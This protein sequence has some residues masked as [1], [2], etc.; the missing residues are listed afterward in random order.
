MYPKEKKVSIFAHVFF[1]FERPKRSTET[2][3]QTGKEASRLF[4]KT[5]EKW[6]APEFTDNIWEILWVEK[7][8][9]KY[10]MTKNKLKKFMLQIF[11]EENKRFQ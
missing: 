6:K 1:F 10:K 5:E 2:K 4:N 9:Q 8:I 3:L 11:T 7:A